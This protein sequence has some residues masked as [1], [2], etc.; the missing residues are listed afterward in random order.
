MNVF[1]L[2]FG[3]LTEMNMGRKALCSTVPA[4]VRE[5]LAMAA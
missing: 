2:H 5:A 3:L 4:T 1:A